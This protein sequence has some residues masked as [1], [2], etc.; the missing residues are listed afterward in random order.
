MYV[1]MYLCCLP[2]LFGIIISFQWDLF[3]MIHVPE[4]TMCFYYM[5]L[6]SKLRFLQARGESKPQAV[7]S[8]HW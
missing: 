7:F 5:A 8:D 2:T 6:T 4:L 3:R 1:V